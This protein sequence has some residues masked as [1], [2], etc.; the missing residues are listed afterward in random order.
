MPFCEW[1]AR[2]ESRI[3]VPLGVLYTTKPTLAVIAYLAPPKPKPI[4]GGLNP[5]PSTA[6]SSA[7]RISSAVRA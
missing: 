3:D 1:T 5:G 4:K 2:D 7:A 6:R